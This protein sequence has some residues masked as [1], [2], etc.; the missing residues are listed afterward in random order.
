[1]NTEKYTIRCVRLKSGALGRCKTDIEALNAK[2]AMTIFIDTYLPPVNEVPFI[3]T[4]HPRDIPGAFV[5]CRLTYSPTHVFFLNSFFKYP[6][7]QS[8][9]IKIMDDTK[10]AKTNQ[11]LSRDQVLDAPTQNMPTGLG[12]EQPST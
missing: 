11:T 4:I 9:P 1:M 3:E 12:A 8:K 5:S 6:Y 10:N 2:E 7:G